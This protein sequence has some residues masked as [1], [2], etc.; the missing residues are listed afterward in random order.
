MWS[1]LGNKGS[2]VNE[3]YPIHDPK[4]LFEKEKNY[5]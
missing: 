4:T 1:I 2:I 5:P 3:D